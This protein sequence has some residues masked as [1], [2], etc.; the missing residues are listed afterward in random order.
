MDI[1]RLSEKFNKARDYE[2]LVNSEG[3]KRLKLEKQ[4]FA[5]QIGQKLIDNGL[6]DNVELTELMMKAKAFQ[7]LFIEIEGIAKQ[8]ERLE[9]TLK[10]MGVSVR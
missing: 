7:D 10:D 6:K 3:Y 2:G 4:E 8:R 5:K 1:K 9:G